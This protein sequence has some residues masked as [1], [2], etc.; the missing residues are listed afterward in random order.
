MKTRSPLRVPESVEH[1]AHETIHTAAVV[2]HTVVDAVRHEADVLADVVLS[3]L[4]VS[5]E[6]LEI[7]FT[8][9]DVV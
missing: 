5:L 8:E 9:D 3:P 4:A 6:G 7:D 2:G 1:A